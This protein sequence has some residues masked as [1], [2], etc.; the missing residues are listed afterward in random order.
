MTRAPE[1]QP[2]LLTT[3]QAAQFLG[4][5]AITLRKLRCKGKL[6]TNIPPVPFIELGRT[7]RYDVDDLR[8]YIMK[9]RKAAL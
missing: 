5:S 3:E 9:H 2:Q 4:V 6:R 7:I 1:I 8:E